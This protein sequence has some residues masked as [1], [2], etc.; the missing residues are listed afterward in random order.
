MRSH[1]SKKLFRRLHLLKLVVATAM[2][3]GLFGLQNPIRFL[4]PV[5]TTTLS[6]GALLS[7]V[8]HNQFLSQSNYEQRLLQQGRR[9][10]RAEQFEQAIAVWLEVEQHFSS[11]R[12]FLGQASVLS[13]LALAHHQ[14]GQWLEAENAIN[15]SLEILN[16]Q[17]YS[18][19]Q[20]SRIYG[21]VL[22]TQGSL[23]LAQGNTAKALESWEQ[24]TEEYTQAKFFE[25]RI[26]SLI[27]QTH[28]LRR[29][30]FLRESRHRLLQIEMLLEKQTDISL[31]IALTR[32]L[33]ENQRLMGEL[34]ASRTSLLKSLELAKM[35][36]GKQDLAA[37]QL[38]LGNTL[39]VSARQQEALARRTQNAIDKQKS[40][41]LY[42]EAEGFYSKVIAGR[43]PLLVQTQARLN[44]L[45][46][47]IQNQNWI[48]AQSAQ[49]SLLSQLDNLPLGRA[50]TF[51]HMRLA[52][53]LM[54][55]CITECPAEMQSAQQQIYPLLTS[56]RQQAKDIGDTIAESYALGYLGH[57]YEIEEQYADAQRLTEAASKQAR[58][59]PSLIY[60]WEWQL[61][62]V[63]NLIGYP[64]E[65]IISHYDTAFENVKKIRSDLLYVGPDIQFHFR[66]HVEPL[67]REYISLLLP[68]DKTGISNNTA[69][70]IRAQTVIDDLRVAELE[71][72]LACGLIEPSD[73]IPRTT[74]QNIA[75]SD[76]T[77]AIIYPITL[78]DGP[79]ADRLE[80]LIQLP[81]NTRD[82]SIKRYPTKIIRSDLSNLD[83][84]H[85]N[86]HVS[87]VEKKLQ[88]L[89]F[90][91]E[92]SHFSFN[93]FDDDESASRGERQFDARLTVNPFAAE[94]LQQGRLLAEEIY[95]WL[96]LPAEEQGWLESM[97]TLV[98]VLDGAFRQ[99]PMAALYDK[100]AKQ[101]LIEK[102]AIAV[103]FGDLAIPQ[104]P[105]KRS[106]R[107]LAGGLS[108]ELSS[109]APLSENSLSSINTDTQ[110]QFN[111]LPFVEDEIES[112]TKIVKNTDSLLNSEFN[113]TKIQTK[114]RLSAYNVVHLATHGVF[115]FTRDDTFLVV[116]APNALEQTSQS[117]IDKQNQLPLQ[118]EKLDL[119]DFDNLLRTR[120]QTP[121][122][123]LV[124]SAC[125]TAT[126]DSREI[127]GIAGL[128]IQSG[129]RSTLASLW[130]IEDF[131]TSV[132]IA[133][134]Y[135]Q[136]V[137][138]G[139]SK[140]KA[141][142]YAQIQLLKQNSRP[143]QW[144]PYLLVGDW[145]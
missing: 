83:G 91:L 25:G 93:S 79:D 100:Q 18:T 54:D 125:E 81:D 47:F 128:A 87:V 76:K 31:K 97:D 116:A 22:N 3:A 8:Q 96:I 32:S 84:V 34:K 113:K 62:R 75:N 101:F 133:H 130:R 48:K 70:L 134:F 39:Q 44:Q 21:Q 145:R 105:P 143:S 138:Q 132:L 86:S 120:N 2:L 42:Q 119:N 40:V 61:G 102:Y 140:A 64:K 58:N 4:S 123:L 99:V 142:Q 46:I 26:K 30:G 77:T 127:L 72:F 20:G 13:N 135:D 14:L 109:I 110:P 108:S 122:E 71:S 51:A 50:S 52:H 36:P 111:Q 141:L 137:N 121:I 56:A 129:A 131:S 88:Q 112:I 49:I 80:V 139:V 6:R 118:I 59:Q 43:A 67:Y 1:F 63:E 60:Q 144:A 94:S 19:T 27:N 41:R 126:G 24:A 55:A 9:L 98:F 104:A 136:L 82:Q 17:K 28:A 7:Q 12:D 38:S 92:S 15:R 57:L 117:A 115:G 107:V 68:K 95:D 29:L 53:L 35:A 10:Y 65:R 85:R 90:E 69:P 16:K 23:H 103:T 37:I 78:S 89:R 73:N 106:F 114:V 45:A 5:T 33:G 124:L 66:D 74:I 11:Q